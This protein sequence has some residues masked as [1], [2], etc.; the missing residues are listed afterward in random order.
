MDSSSV[1][2]YLQ[3]CQNSPNPPG[4]KVTKTKVSFR[5]A[6]AQAQH[7]ARSLRLK[8]QGTERNYEQA[9]KGVAEYL[10]EQRLGDLRHLDKEKA[11]LYLEMRSQ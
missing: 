9:L 11:E 10:K 4:P 5:N 7:A 8:S 3:N 1:R 2:R 6:G